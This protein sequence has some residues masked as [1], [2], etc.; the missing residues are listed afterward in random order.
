MLFSPTFIFHFCLS[1][2]SFTFLV[3]FLFPFQFSLLSFANLIHFSFSSFALLLY[4][5]YP[6]FVNILHFSHR[7]HLRFLLYRFYIIIIISFPFREFLCYFF[8]L[9]RTLFSLTSHTY[10]YCHVRYLH[11]SYFCFL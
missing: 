1:L 8:H 4:R 6:T 7:F 3:F 11:L 5:R 10:N 9:H 2:I